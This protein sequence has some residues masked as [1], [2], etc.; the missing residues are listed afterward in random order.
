M[1]VEDAREAIMDSIAVWFNQP[2]RTVAEARISDALSLDAVTA[3]GRL[4]L[5][6]QAEMLCYW[7][8][9]SEEEDGRTATMAECGGAYPSCKAR[10]KLVPVKG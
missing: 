7:V 8:W 2:V 9:E 3:I 5:E 4:I 1:S 6:V 10:A